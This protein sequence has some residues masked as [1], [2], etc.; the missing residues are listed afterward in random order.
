MSEVTQALQGLTQYLFTENQRLDEVDQKKRVELAATNIASKFKNLPEGATTAEIQAL[1]F[2]AIEDAAALGGLQENLP[3]ISSAYQSVLYTREAEKRERQDKI[4]S[5]IVFKQFGGAE[6]LSGVDQINLAN[7]ERSQERQFNVI[8]EEGITRSLVFDA[9]GKETFRQ[10]INAVGFDIK[11]SQ[12]ETQALFQ[13]GL[14]KDLLR[15]KTE[16]KATSE[17]GAQQIAGYKFIKTK[18]GRK[19]EPLYT[20]EDG[21]GLYTVRADGEVIAFPT[22]PNSVISIKGLG[23]ETKDILT[24]LQSIK[25]TFSGAKY[26][27]LSGVFEGK[28]GSELLIAITGAETIHKLDKDSGEDVLTSGAVKRIEAFFQQD[29]ALVR[30]VLHGKR[31]SQGRLIDEDEPGLLNE[32]EVDEITRSLLTEFEITFQSEQSLR[33]QQLEL[34]PKSDLDQITDVKSYNNGL[35]MLERGIT[36]PNVPDSLKQG[37]YNYIANRVSII[38]SSTINMDHFNSMTIEDRI[39]LTKSITN[40]T[41]K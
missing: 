30:E 16:L 32:L 37:V 9:R 39:Q 40:N 19:G 20:K 25:D 21:T 13:H 36:D 8:D 23:A 10:E 41:F 1:Q 5:D 6:G 29:P 24:N 17:A 38:D 31:D 27:A 35:I 34:I 2:E 7:L 14:S 26:F 3:L 33:K 18:Q 28:K 11:Q 15:F 4:L 22:G 12:F